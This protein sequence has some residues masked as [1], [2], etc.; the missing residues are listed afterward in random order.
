MADCSNSIANCQQRMGVI[1]KITNLV[2][3]KIYVGQ[4][5]QK[6]SRR[7]N[8]HKHGNGEGVDQAIKKYGIENFKIEP[9]EK[10]PREM[11]NDREMFW[12]KELN[13]IAPNGYNLTEGGQSDFRVSE[14]TKEKLRIINIGKTL[15][16]ETKAKISESEQGEKNPFYGKHHTPE[17]KAKISAIH[18]G[19]VISPETRAKMSEAHKNPSPETRAK[20]SASRTGEKNPFY[21]KHHTAETKAKISAKKK[22]K[23][24]AEEKSAEIAISLFEDDNN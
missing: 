22:A 21:G 2:D 19:K 12:I 17:T 9:I 15:S 3:G 13:C 11:L 23:K 6:L 1:Y 16:A 8:Q 4:T 10:C 14:A 18:K 5:V 20:L 7:F 24:L